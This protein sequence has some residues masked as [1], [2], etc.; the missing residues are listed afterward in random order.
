MKKLFILL[1]LGA[2]A[3]GTAAWAATETQKSASPAKAG[4]A[5]CCGFCEPDLP[6]GF[7]D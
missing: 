2:L 5:H 7:C 3:S 6:C 1:V 4:A